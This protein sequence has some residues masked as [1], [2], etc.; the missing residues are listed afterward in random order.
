MRRI[1]QMLKILNVS[2]YHHK[3]LTIFHILGSDI[4]A[5]E[6]DNDSEDSISLGFSDPDQD[7]EFITKNATLNQ[8]MNLDPD[9]KTKIKR[10]G[11]EYD[12]FVAGGFGKGK[13]LNNSFTGPYNS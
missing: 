2:L 9:A 10:K 1:E 4:E 6:G 11:E 3:T 12:L 5:G 13:P 7:H 8:S